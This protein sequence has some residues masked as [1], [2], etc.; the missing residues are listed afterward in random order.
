MNEVLDW[1]GILS[2]FF[3]FLGGIF[4][5]LAWLKL[6]AVDKLNEKV[7]IVLKLEG[8]ESEITLPLELRRR[9]VTR[10]EVLGRLGMLPMAE[11]GNRFS[12]RFLST[13]DFFKGLNDVA[14]NKTDTLVIPCTEEEINQF[15]L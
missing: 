12:L 3:G 5:T 15:D 11:K 9:D 10:A 14:E 13:T 6:R 7:E 2:N 8:N 4:A 1:I